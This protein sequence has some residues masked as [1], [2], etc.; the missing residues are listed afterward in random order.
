M[1]QMKLAL[2]TLPGVRT[3][4]PFGPELEARA[5]RAAGLVEVA[6]HLDGPL[7]PALQLVVLAA[8]AAVVPQAAKS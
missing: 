6:G 4:W 3:G 8:L 2:S 1:L 5:R 7:H